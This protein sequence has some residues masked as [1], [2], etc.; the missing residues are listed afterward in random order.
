[1]AGRERLNSVIRAFEA[2]MPAFASFAT[3]DASTAISFS[4][5][6]Y[7]NVVFEMEHQPW[8]ALALRDSLQY[9]LNRRLIA[10]SGSVASTVTPFVRVPANG[11]E[12]NQWMAKQALDMGCY[13]I[14]WPH[15]ATVDEAR[16]AVAA[17]RYP[18]PKGSP[19]YEPAGLRGDS[20]T[21]AARY[22]GISLQD[23]YD[24]ADVWPL[25]PNGE[26]LCVIMI[27][28]EDGIA[29]LDAMLRNVPGIGLI[30]IGQGDLS[31]VLGV[32]RKYEH[33]KVISATAEIRAICKKYGVKVGRPQVDAD[34]IEAALA[35]DYDY[36]MPA[37]TRSL[38]A[39]DKGLQ[40]TKRSSK[41]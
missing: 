29:N 21:A 41:R 31:R 17:C 10:Q 22:W 1:M 7:D 30:L 12:M 6:A 20:P 3:A 14:V 8:D 26:I 40:L 28:C 18:R 19:N 39:L 16:A 38:A 9:L 32:P 5:T 13:G 36:L 34:N 11:S 25:D 15:V 33:P 27:E 35:D 2:K 37:P 4:D 23:Y 24:R